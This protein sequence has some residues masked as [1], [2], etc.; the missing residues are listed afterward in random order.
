[1]DNRGDRFVPEV[2]GIVGTIMLHCPTQA[3]LWL[4]QHLLG[5][6]RSICQSKC[7][8]K[9]KEIRESY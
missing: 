6:R 7:L 5:T 3:Y 9:K 8:G 4:G 2:D 1:M